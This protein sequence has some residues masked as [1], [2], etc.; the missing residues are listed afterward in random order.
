MCCLGRILHRN[1]RESKWR[2]AAQR[3]AAMLYLSALWELL[4]SSL[5]YRPRSSQSMVAYV[6]PQTQRVMIGRVIN[7]S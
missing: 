5:D 7:S 4:V 6:G 1:E 3:K 2:K